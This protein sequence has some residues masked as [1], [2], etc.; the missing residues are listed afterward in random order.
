MS[1]AL[2][3]KINQELKAYTKE[4]AYHMVGDPLVLGNL[5]AYLDISL[6]NNLAVNLTTTGNNLTPKQFEVLSHKAIKQINFSINSYQAN[7]HKKVWK[8]I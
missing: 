1:V 8:S 4:L 7:S 3:E 2:F 5:N 6:A